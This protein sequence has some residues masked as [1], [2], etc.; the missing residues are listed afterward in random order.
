[1]SIAPAP[2]PTD[3]AGPPD[4]WAAPSPLGPAPPD[5]P[6]ARLRVAVWRARPTLAA[7]AVV[8]LVLV[9]ARLAAPPPA[10]TVPVVVTAVDVAAG[11]TLDAAALRVVAA[12][13]GAVP[14]G[15]PRTVDAVVGREALVP[16][17]AGLPVV[18][19]VLAGERFAV[20]APRGTVV[21]AV[22]LADPAVSGL[23]R[24]GD[25]VDLVTAATGA[26]QPV[27]ADVVA[28][29][30]L[31]LDRTSV[32]ATTGPLGLG[33]ADGGAV[34]TV[35]AVPPEDGRRLA[36]VVGWADLGAVLVG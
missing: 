8:G 16:L 21:V 17:P 34:L 9:A 20:P 13:P 15:A 18:A 35:V 29:G 5:P 6:A 30:A 31:V 22:R 12:P 32:T 28:R 4:A 11:A 33:S 25:R 19:E 7:L 10:P 23:L 1:M 2:W 14:D 26:A 3:G 27:A 36:A 24:P